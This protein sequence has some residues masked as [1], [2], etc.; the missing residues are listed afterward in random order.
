MSERCEPV[1]RKALSLAYNS[2]DCTGTFA[3]LKNVAV[4]GVQLI[5]TAAASSAMLMD[6]IISKCE[7][8]IMIMYVR[9]CPYP[10]RKA[11]AASNL[12]VELYSIDEAN[13]ACDT[14]AVSCQMNEP[15]IEV[16]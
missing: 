4:V 11:A 5:M 2:Q 16:I 9:R 15:L 1:R 8:E 7:I 13:N 10:Y 6:R 14:G 12:H 3:C